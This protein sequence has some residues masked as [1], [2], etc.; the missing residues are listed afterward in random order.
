MKKSIIAATLIVALTSASMA[1]AV[2]PVHNMAAFKNVKTKSVS[3]TEMNQ[4]SGQIAP[5]I[6]YYAAVY[7]VPLSFAFM[8][9]ATSPT[10]SS[11]IAR[12]ISKIRR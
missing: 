12:A 3:D 10:G 2:E 4:V 7:G 5:I 6:L 1:F 11:A 9:W 8:R